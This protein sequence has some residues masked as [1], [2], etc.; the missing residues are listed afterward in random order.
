MVSLLRQRLEAR[1]IKT[2]QIQDFGQN[3]S[4]KLKE[5]IFTAKV[6][7]AQ[8]EISKILVLHEKE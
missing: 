4:K 7:N 2:E 8:A 3:W 1:S 6:S 5:D